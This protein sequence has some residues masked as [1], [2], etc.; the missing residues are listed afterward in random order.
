MAVKD[1]ERV[2]EI[3]AVRE[4]L[5]EAESLLD[6]LSAS[7]DEVRARAREKAAED[8]QMTVD[9]LAERAGVSVDVVTAFVETLGPLLDKRGLS[10]QAARRAAIVAAAEG[11]WERELGPLLGSAEVRELLGGVSRQRVDELLRER[12]LIGLR[13]AS[14]RRQ[15]PVFQFSDGRILDPIV[16]AYWTV[17]PSIA[18]DWTAASWCVAADE[19]VL[20][21][22]SPA[23]FARRDAD[24]ARL[25]AVAARDAARLAH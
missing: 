24:P 3:D 10:V 21:G 8:P 2:A 6:A 14:G 4:S 19:E 16:Q 25:A 23:A 20:D 12:K 17:R 22:L 5:H 13:A 9:Q 18:D 11:V 1:K 7:L 15:F